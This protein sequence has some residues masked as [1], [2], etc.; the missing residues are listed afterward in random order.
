MNAYCRAAEVLGQLKLVVDIGF[1]I[2]RHDYP[3]LSAH[4]HLTLDDPGLEEMESFVCNLR[5]GD[6][7][8][9]PFFVCDMGP[10]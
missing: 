7:L 10:R 2:E 1:V 4:Y 5:E 3:G 6:I 9:T 8:S